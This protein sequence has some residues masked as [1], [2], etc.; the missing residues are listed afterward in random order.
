MLSIRIITQRRGTLKV[1][2]YCIIN[3]LTY[4]IPVECRHKGTSILVRWHVLGKLIYRKNIVLKDFKKYEDK[5]KV[6]EVVRYSDK[7]VRGIANA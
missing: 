1:P 2:S 6:G 7:E 3:G 4:Y 5:F